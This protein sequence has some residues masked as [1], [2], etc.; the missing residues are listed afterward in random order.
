MTFDD[1]WE[2][3]EQE[4]RAFEVLARYHQEWLIDQGLPE[5]ERWYREKKC[6][7]DATR[8][9]KLR[10]VKAIRDNLIRQRSAGDS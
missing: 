7:D 4:Q 9:R 10:A 8:T 5:L 2:E 3:A 6:L 1:G